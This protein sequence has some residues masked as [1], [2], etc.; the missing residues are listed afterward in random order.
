MRIA[1]VV[2]CALGGLSSGL[3]G[4]KWVSDA[5]KAQKLMAVAE[6]LGIA[7]DA[8]AKMKSIK[9]SGYLLVLSGLGA[10]GAAAAVTTRKEK[11]VG[12]VLLV[13]AIVPALFAAKALVATFFLLVAGGLCFAIKP[14]PA[15]VSERAMRRIAW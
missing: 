12:G 5:N 1:V 14:A 15:P 4:L 3:L 11:T 9:T 8:V 2:L 13:A 10:F 7:K 6:E